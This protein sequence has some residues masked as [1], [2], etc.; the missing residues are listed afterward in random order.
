MN[1]ASSTRLVRT[2]SHLRPAQIGRQLWMRALPGWDDASWVADR[3]PPPPPPV[4]WHP[5]TTWLP[6]GPYANT[7]ADLRAG[8]FT[9]LNQTRDLGWPPRWHVP[10]APLLWQLNLHYLEWIWALP[11]AEATAAALDWASRNPPARKA[12]AWWPYT[13]SLRLAALCLLAGESPAAA[14]EL[15]PT[16]WRQTEHLSRRL[17]YHLLANHLLENAV[18]LAFVGACYSGPDADRWRALGIRLLREQLPEQI[19]ADGMHE[20]R[21]PMYHLRLTH[22]LALLAN[23]GDATVRGVVV[24]PLGR[25]LQALVSVCHP[26]GEIALFNDSAIGTYP[27]PA[28]VLDF[29]SRALGTPAPSVP[30]DL[31]AAGYYRGDTRGNDAVICD[32]GL[33]APDHQPGHAHGDMF[34]FEL[35]LAGRRVIV[36]SGTFEYPPGEMRT[37][38]RSTRA[39]NTVTVDDH[40]QAEF[41]GS[42]RVGRRGRPH[43][44]RHQALADGFS[45]EGWHDGYRHLPAAAIHRRRF[46]WHDSGRLEIHD[47]VTAK[48]PVRASARLHLHPEC[49]IVDRDDRTV[50]VA[51]GDV[52]FTVAFGPTGSLRAEEGWYC[53]R[54]GVRERTTVL[55]REATSTDVRIE[56]VIGHVTRP[57][58]PGKLTS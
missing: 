22:A 28:A 30:G 14:R 41:W 46:R 50:R 34:S 51:C 53:P 31:T 9:F 57:A 25:M 44:V 29:A 43:D 54:S 20:E 48:R 21:A 12:V 24:E 13:T 38:C 58:P 35:S 56:C 5:V 42:F 1:L 2:L 19:L 23:T 52:D 40:D 7:A 45:L 33:L 55:V 39:H 49:Q 8:R 4:R 47:R 36:D 37:W 27:A 18:A 15:W 10:E 32:A 3:A 17:E 6:S 16:I 26:D 11:A